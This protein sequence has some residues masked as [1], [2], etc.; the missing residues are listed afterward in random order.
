MCS[1]SISKIKVLPKRY[2]TLSNNCSLT[3]VHHVVIHAAHCDHF[4]EA[5]VVVFPLQT[6]G[7]VCVVLEQVAEELQVK[8]DH[9]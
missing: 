6:V 3:D 5:V 1:L 2:V 8:V 4:H 7:Q 9:Q